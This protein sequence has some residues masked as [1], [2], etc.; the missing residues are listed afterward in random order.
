MLD[1]FG[2]HQAKLASKVSSSL[3]GNSVK[4]FI[5]RIAISGADILKT[6]PSNVCFASVFVEF[7]YVFEPINSKSKEI[8]RV[9]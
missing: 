4:R 1:D 8:S 3:Y 6:E 5:I 9:P 2:I 7:V